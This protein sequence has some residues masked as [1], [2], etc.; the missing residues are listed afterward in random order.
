M[1][2]MSDNDEL[3]RREIVGSGVGVAISGI[4][5]YAVYETASQMFFG[6]VEHRLTVESIGE[7]PYIDGAR[8]RRLSRL[9]EDDY[10]L[11]LEIP[12]NPPRWPDHYVLM[13]N[14]EQHINANDSPPTGETVAEIGDVKSYFADEYDEVLVIK[15]GFDN[16]E[17]HNGEIL[18]RVPITLAE[19]K[20]ES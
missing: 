7:S 4:G 9:I 12:E 2:A 10:V 5:L 19:T 13:R 14:G 15:G 20:V 11:V 3:T 1:V 18:D 16:G 8:V 6:G 17:I